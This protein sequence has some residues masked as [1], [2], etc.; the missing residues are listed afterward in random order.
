MRGYIFVGTS[1]L[2]RSQHTADLAYSIVLPEHFYWIF[3]RRHTTNLVD[4]EGEGHYSEDP[5]QCQTTDVEG[6]GGHREMPEACHTILTLRMQFSDLLE[7]ILGLRCHAVTLPR[8]V[9]PLCVFLL[10]IRWAERHG[11]Y[12]IIGRIPAELNL[13]ETCRQMHPI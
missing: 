7:L 12:P 13:A 10:M 6:E 5:E 3:E 11:L 8:Y 9:R 2:L 1:S 4:V